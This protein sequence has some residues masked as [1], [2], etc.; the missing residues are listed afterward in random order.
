MASVRLARVPT[1]EPR[2]SLLS[3]PLPDLGLPDASGREFRLRQF[4]G[5]RP[6]VLFFYILNGSPG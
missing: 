4:V 6:L 3:Q 1:S 5:H 2:D